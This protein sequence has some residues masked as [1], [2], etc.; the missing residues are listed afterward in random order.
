MKLLIHL[1]KRLKKITKIKRKKLWKLSGEG[2][3]K[4]LLNER[5]NCFD[6]FSQY[7]ETFSPDFTNIA[8]LVM[9][10]NLF[11]DPK[12]I[13]NGSANFDK[14]TLEETHNH[15][16]LEKSSNVV[17]L[18]D[19]RCEGKL[20]NPNVINLS[21]RH[22]SKD[23]FSLLSKGLKFIPTPKHINKACIKE[24]LQ[25]YGRKFRLMWHYCNEE[26]DPFKKES[27]FN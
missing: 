15:P 13:L 25:T 1:E 17:T 7:C 23:E 10:E 3:I 14:V 4:E 24:E 26:L 8:N 5:F 18:L 21:K 6:Y 9:L 20:L 11:N 16:S 12:I 22:L 27:K 2:V 19:G